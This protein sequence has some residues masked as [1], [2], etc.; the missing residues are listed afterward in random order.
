MS[1]DYGI[2]QLSCVESGILF[3]RC[4]A[5]S[6]T[7][8]VSRRLPRLHR[9]VLFNSLYRSSRMAWWWYADDLPSFWRL[10]WD[11]SNEMAD[12][13]KAF[14]EHRDVLSQL[15]SLGLHIGENDMSVALA[16]A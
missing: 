11:G 4:P 1:G 13:Y 2:A 15:V 7:S 8:V 12:A 10:L 14:M 6:S 16:L 5:L 3:L 9:V